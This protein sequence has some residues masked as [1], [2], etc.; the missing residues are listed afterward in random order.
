MPTPRESR[1][2]SSAV[3]DGGGGGFRRPFVKHIFVVCCV[4][5]SHSARDWA[6]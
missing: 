5:G 4:R 3:Y 6:L 1:D 2:A